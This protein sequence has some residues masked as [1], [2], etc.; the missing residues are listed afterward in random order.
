[1]KPNFVKQT[2]KRYRNLSYHGMTMGEGGCGVMSVYNIVSKKV[3]TTPKKVWKYMTSKGYVIPHQGTTW[4]GITKSLKHFG[5]KFKVT[6]S[7]TEV[8]KSLKKGNW[9]LGLCGRSRWTTSGHYIVI[10]KLTPKGHI[11]CSDP[12]SASDYCQKDGTLKEYLACNKCT[13]I[14]IDPTLS[15][16]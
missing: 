2:D 4:D 12:Y 3:K 7:D 9:L 11:Y 14:D 15:A 6:Y 8:R 1:M 5:V 16:V 10:Y 13:W